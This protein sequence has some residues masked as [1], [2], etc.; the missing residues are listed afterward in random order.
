MNYDVDIVYL[1][2]T[3]QFYARSLLDWFRYGNTECLSV[4]FWAFPLWLTPAKRV[5]LELRESIV[6]EMRSISSCLAYS[7]PLVT[8]ILFSHH[9]DFEA[10]NPTIVEIVGLRSL[11]RE[12]SQRFHELEDQARRGNFFI[13]DLKMEEDCA[14][15]V[16]RSFRRRWW[17]E[18][19]TL[20]FVKIEQK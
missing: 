15:E 18:T 19:P 7:C 1:T 4:A 2:P 14:K 9:S 3:S 13:M 10:N 6:Y 8:E 20:K 17:F 11:N 16:G 12:I 5:T